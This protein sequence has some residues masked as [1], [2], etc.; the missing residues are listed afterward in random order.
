MY[1]LLIHNIKLYY[2]HIN[3]ILYSDIVLQELF[4]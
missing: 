2:N 4:S 3:I 1:N